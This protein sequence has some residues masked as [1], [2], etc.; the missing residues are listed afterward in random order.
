[1]LKE[2]ETELNWTHTE[3]G[4]LAYYGT[5]NACL[6][7]FA[8]AGA[9]RSADES[10]IER[11]FQLAYAENPDDAM[12][13]LFYLRDVRGGLGER[14]LF[15]VL[16]QFAS[17]RYPESV[18]KNLEYIPEYGRFDDCLVLLNTPC[19][20]ALV[21]MI[22]NQL[23]TDIQDMQSGKPVSLLAKWLP[24][25]N[26]SSSAVREQAKQLCRL[27]R[28]SEKAYRKTLSQLRTYLDVLEKRL[29][30]RDYTFDYEALPSK[31]LYQYQKAFRKH[32]G[33]RYESF[34]NRVQAGKAE[35]KAKNIFPYEIIR[36]C[37]YPHTKEERRTLD[38]TWKSLPNYTD[39][40]NAI[41]VV[42]GSASMY[43]REQCHVAPITVAVSLGLYFAERSQGHFHDYF[44][45]FSDNPRLIKVKGKDIVRKAEYC[46][47][48]NE[49][50]NTNLERVFELL[51]YTAVNHHLPQE[52]LP[53]IIYI[54]SDMEFDEQIGTDKTIFQWMQLKYKKAGYQLPL[55]VYWNVCNRNQQYP[56]R[57]DET[58]AILVSG[59]NPVVFRS[60]MDL[61]MTPEKYMRDVLD[62]KRY[63]EIMA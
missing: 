34:L 55:V 15:R 40:R 51:L 56:V 30:A 38:L 33:I 37:M 18:K 25:V 54:I 24:S 28:L 35:L 45:T 22:Q 17:F 42:D 9:L 61:N 36:R 5:Q 26:T 2:L 46:M 8:A 19:E 53:E 20:A 6:D 57:K 23:N 41:A 12:R 43:W 16:L 14:W 27:L 49:C 1:M 60:A 21:S 44:I 48:Y 31:A 52:E 3:N 39:N 59:C 47:G 32:D 62:G 13:I 4:A 10:R 7:L 63:C 58:G 11:M 29:C 50:A